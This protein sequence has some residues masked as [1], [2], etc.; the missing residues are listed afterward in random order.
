MVATIITRLL[1]GA[2]ARLRRLGL[3][4]SAVS[5]L[6]LIVSFAIHFTTGHGR[7]MPEQLSFGEF[8]VAHPAYVVLA[9]IA[10]ITLWWL[11]PGEARSRP[12]Q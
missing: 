5:L 3:A 7:G 8:L 10:S 6:F 9:F 12:L 11:R 1:D 4:S 2:S